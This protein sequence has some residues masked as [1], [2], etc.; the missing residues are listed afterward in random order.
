MLENDH[1]ILNATTG[2]GKTVI[3]SYLIAKRGV[4]ALILV[5]SKSL[6]EQWVNELNKFLIINEPM[7]TYKTKGGKIK[8]RNSLIGVL[9]GN[10]N[11]LTGIIDVAMIG[12]INNKDIDNTYGLVIMDECHHCGSLTSIEVINKIRARYV[13][14]VSATV[15]RSDNLDKI[16]YFLLGPIRHS[17]TSKEN[18]SKQGI[19]HYVYP[20]FTRVVYTNNEDKDINSSYQLISNNKARNELIIDNTKEVIKNGR[21]VL[22]LTKYKEQAKSLHDNLLKEADYVFLLYGDNGDK[23]NTMIISGLKDIPDDKSVIVVATG[24]KIGEGF[25]FPRLDT[26]MLACPVSFGGRLEQYV[27]RINRNYKNKKDVIVYDYVDSHLK[28][29]ENMYF[30]R[31][32]TYK[33]LGYE[34]ISNVDLEKQRTN[35]IFDSSNY[36]DVFERDLLE[37]NKRIVVSSPYLSED[38]IDRFIQITATKIDARCKITIITLNPDGVLFNNVGDFY[39]ILKKLKEA[40]IEVIVK[41]DLN[42]HFAV[43]D[44]DLCWHGGMNLLGKEDIYDNLMRIKSAK[45]AEELLEMCLAK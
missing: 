42:E 5:Q 21:T 45:I 29:F 43:I 28:V 13:Y 23:E 11:T 8:S 7:P 35:A 44:D 10:K 38:K 30:K 12:S 40:G 16:I 24:Q 20:V 22:V 41:D 18:I 9:S 37:A 39:E 3:S 14:G 25:D 1:G 27:G 17:Y 36:F 19:G 26:L 4:S 34:L 6:L 33:R 32:K 15:M 2:F 31:L